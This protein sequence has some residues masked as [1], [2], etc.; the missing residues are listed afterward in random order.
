MTAL[1]R[2]GISALCLGLLIGCGPS[3]QYK[4][5]EQLKSER[6]HDHDHEHEHGHGAPGP[7][8]GA[9]VELGQEEYHAEVVV[10]DKTHSLQ[11]YLLGKDAKSASPIAATEVTVG[12]G[13]DKSVTLKAAPQEGDG[14][15]KSSKF[16]LADEKVVHDLLDAGFLHG[17]LKVQIGDKAYEGHIDAHFEHD[18]DHADEKKTEAAPA[19]DKKADA[20]ADAKPEEKKE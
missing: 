18:H 20:P 13:G 11:V 10:D 19:E 15:G 9:L 2:C 5:N 8:G 16:E 4:T 17:S 14:E 6:G 7:H 3:A 1:L 12:L